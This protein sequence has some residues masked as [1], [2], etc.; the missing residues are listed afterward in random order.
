MALL[1]GATLERIDQAR[2]NYENAVAAAHEKFDEDVADCWLRHFGAWPFYVPEEDRRNFWTTGRTYKDLSE[3][4]RK[5]RARE[6]CRRLGRAWEEGD[7]EG[8]EEWEKWR[9][10]T[11]G[12]EQI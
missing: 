2:Q 11:N 3:E 4:E 10:W 6:R 7:E 12:P 9:W 5:E 8:A 1:N